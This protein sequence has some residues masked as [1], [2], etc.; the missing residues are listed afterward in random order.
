MKWGGGNTAYLLC[1]VC[2][3]L[4]H[5]CLCYVAVSSE[6]VI[7]SCLNGS[8]VMNNDLLNVSI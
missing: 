7:R 3:Q 1:D 4:V 6:S 2:L 8:M 5:V